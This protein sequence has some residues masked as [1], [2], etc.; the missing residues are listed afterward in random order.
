MSIIMRTIEVPDLFN[1]LREFN[2]DGSEKHVV[3][4]G[5]RYHV[6]SYHGTT[7]GAAVRCSEKNCELNRSH[8]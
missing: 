3:C 5:A 7:E 1:Y 8:P 2:E 6:L 4:D